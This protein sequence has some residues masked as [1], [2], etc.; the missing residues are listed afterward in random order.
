MVLGGLFL[1]ASVL[2]RDVLFVQCVFLDCDQIF[3]LFFPALF[4][5]DDGA[6]GAEYGGAADAAAR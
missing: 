2:E 3:G 6:L 4:R 1:G 5:C